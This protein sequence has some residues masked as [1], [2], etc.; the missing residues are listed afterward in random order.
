MQPR[1]AV[2]PRPLS[3]SGARQQTGLTRVG[4]GMLPVTSGQTSEHNDLEAAM[5]E[6]VEHLGS[7]RLP[8]ERQLPDERRA[9]ANGIELCYL[10]WEGPTQPTRPPVV[11]LHG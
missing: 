4:L 3:S 6:A 5:T 11:V 1:S 8:G 9:R 7:S 2:S 10:E